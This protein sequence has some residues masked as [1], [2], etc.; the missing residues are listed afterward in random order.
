MFTYTLYTCCIVT[1]QYKGIWT[2]TQ[3]LGPQYTPVTYVRAATIEYA[4]GICDVCMN[5]N[6]LIRGQ[7]HTG[8][9]VLTLE[10]LSMSS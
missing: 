7:F 9:D 6:M 2:F 10:F 1:V 5:R 8:F 3:S 4:T